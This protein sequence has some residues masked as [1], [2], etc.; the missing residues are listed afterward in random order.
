MSDEEHATPGATRSTSVR[1]RWLP[2]IGIA[3]GVL[4]GLLA[5]WLW[6]ERQ[7]TAREL[8]AKSALTD[9][10]AL[11]VMDGSRKHVSSLNLSTLSDAE[12]LDKALE[13][14]PH[15]IHLSS[16]DASRT[17]IRDEQLKQVGT[18]SGL[19]TLTL[20]STSISDA[21]IAHL[22]RLKKL[23]ALHL[24]GTKVSNS[25]LNALSS[26]EGLK[27]LDLSATA[28]SGNLSKLSSLPQLDWL[29]LRNLTLEGDALGELAGCQQLS[30]LSLEGSQYDQE[31]F[32]KLR[33]SHPT[34]DV[35]Q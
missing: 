7:A 31:S 10:G 30:R 13:H 3:V 25:G 8:T 12:K 32:E 24:T 2:I 34:I 19:E 35:D 9:L 20:T 33:Q 4:I 27:V 26:L 28:V 21:G 17:P 29:V 11:V 14:V 22:A 18:L 15:L 1:A 23:Q 6:R 5:W 16:F